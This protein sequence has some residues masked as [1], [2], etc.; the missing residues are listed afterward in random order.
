MHTARSALETLLATITEALTP[1]VV[2]L[3]GHATDGDDAEV[4]LTPVALRRV[5]RSRRDGAL[6]DLE[7]TVAVTTLGPDAIDHLEQLL[8]LAET[9]GL[10][11][12]APPAPPVL[13]LTLALPVTV[14]IDEPTGP[15]VDTVV[16]DVRPS[17]SRGGSPGVPVGVTN[18]ASTHAVETSSPPEGS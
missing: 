9:R 3:A 15:R 16:V 10:T 1:A 11:V 8:V 18:G 17:A 14:S 7:L 6:L 2:G 5:G 12:W 13:G 4:V